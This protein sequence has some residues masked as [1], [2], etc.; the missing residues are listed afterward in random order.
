MLVLLLQ[1]CHEHFPEPPDPA[2]NEAPG[3]EAGTC[4]SR[5]SKS[6]MQGHERMWA[7]GPVWLGSKVYAVSRSS[8]TLWVSEVVGDRTATHKSLPNVVSQMGCDQAIRGLWP[9]DGMLILQTAFCAVAIDAATLESIWHTRPADRER[10]L[11]VQSGNEGSVI[12]MSD[13]GSVTARDSRTGRAVWQRA[14]MQEC[15]FA[16]G[17]LWSLRVPSE[18]FVYSADGGRFLWT[19]SYEGPLQAVAVQG[20]VLTLTAGRR[21]TAFSASVGLRMWTAY[22]PGEVASVTGGSDEF[23]VSVRSEPTPDCWSEEST[24]LPNQIYSV[25]SQD[26]ATRWSRDGCGFSPSLS[27]SSHTLVVCENLA[28]TASRLVTYGTKDGQERWSRPWAVRCGWTS[29]IVPLRGKD[30][31]LVYGRSGLVVLDPRRNSVVGVPFWA[32]A[33]ENSFR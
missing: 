7:G 2:C 14:E 11:G 32:A 26:G 18:I 23:L 22:F 29:P 24:G 17:I 21:V 15:G 25:G 3:S 16:A 28:A 20:D 12:L 10:V 13:R 5:Q 31:S 30:L 33:V 4:Q 27:V 6:V 8:A 19:E 9:V 1:S